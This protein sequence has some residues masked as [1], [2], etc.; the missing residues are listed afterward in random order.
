MNI[1]FI[2]QMKDKVA[3]E[4]PTLDEVLEYNWSRQLFVSEPKFLN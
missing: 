3:D 1:A 2:N 4:R